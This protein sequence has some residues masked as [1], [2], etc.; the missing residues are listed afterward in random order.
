M[1]CKDF[2]DDDVVCICSQIAL[3]ENII[4]QL[5]TPKR[6]IFR[7]P[8]DTEQQPV[9]R[10]S[11]IARKLSLV[12]GIP[13][14]SSGKEQSPESPR[15]DRR[16][17]EPT[18]YNQIK[19]KHEYNTQNIPGLRGRDIVAVAILV[20]RDGAPLRTYTEHQDIP[21]EEIEK[22]EQI[23]LSRVPVPNKNDKSQILNKVDQGK[24]KALH[25][26]L[27]GLETSKKEKLF[28]KM[29]RVLLKLHTCDLN[30]A[31]SFL[32]NERYNAVKR[33]IKSEMISFVT[34]DLKMTPVKLNEIQM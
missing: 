21:E 13:C 1:P 32:K 8:S 28:R 14:D 34:K 19:M 4:V 20:N 10:K 12:N 16:N 3:D 15:L 22:A 5:P 24:I 7:R 25:E 18:I 27:D 23:F 31:L 11:S 30:T 9:Q 29:E 2:S 33:E 26:V 17:S 6:S